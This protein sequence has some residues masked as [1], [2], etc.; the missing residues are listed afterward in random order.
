MP[1][2]V[3]WNPRRRLRRSGV[4]RVVRTPSRVNN[5]G[6]LLGPLIARRLA[7]QL[8]LPAHA[9]RGKR[10]LTVGSIMHLAEEGDV[11]WGSGVNGKIQRNSFPDLDVRAVRGPLTARVL[12]S[13]NIA[14][15]EVF[16]DPALLLPELWSLDQLG[17]QAKSGGTL[18]VPN[19]HDLPTFPK[20]S[21]DPRGDPLRRVAQ[22]ASAEFVVSSSLHGIIVAEAYGV[23]V[24]PVVSHSEPSFK[25]EDYFEGTGRR[26]P[27]FSEHPIR[28]AETSGLA[29]LR[30]DSTGL[31]SAFPTDAWT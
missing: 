3:H 29:P 21:L 14:V 16:G 6:D 10:L 11:I 17:V 24:A 31:L 18:F 9:H 4:L 27:R 25:Y 15:P 12:K 28:A 22:I 23:P 13:S 20:G 8:A 5:F 19:L 26:L 1:E 7:E 2:L 30:W